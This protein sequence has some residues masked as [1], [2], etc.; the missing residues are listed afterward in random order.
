L[1][2]D[3]LALPP[4]LGSDCIAGKD[5]P[6]EPRLDGVEP[7]RL[8]VRTRAQDRARGDAKARRAMEDGAI[9]ARRLGVLRVRVQRVLVPIEPIQEC[10]IGWCRQIADQFRR[11]LRYRMRD[12]RVTHPAAEAAV[13]ARE[14]AAVHGR[15]RS[16]VLAEKLA[17]V[18]DDGR[19]ARTVVACLLDARA[20]YR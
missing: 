17:R 13:L 15:N 10:E 8:G 4:H 1:E 2:R 3:A 9:E 14:R 7:F 20:A 11:G 18:L 6:R 16:A 5:R 19:V 12:R